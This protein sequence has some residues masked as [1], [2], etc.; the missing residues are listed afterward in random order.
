MDTKKF[1]PEVTTSGFIYLV[2]TVLILGHMSRFEW[3]T[4][5]GMLDRVKDLNAGLAAA[6]AGSIV[7]ASFVFGS[8]AGR[9]VGDVCEILGKLLRKHV[10]SPA[11]TEGDR[12][13]GLAMKK[14]PEILSEELQGRYVAKY[15]YRSLLF[16]VFW[17]QIGLAPWTL[18]SSDSRTMCASILI[19]VAIDCVLVAVFWSQ[20]RSYSS[21]LL[22]L[23]ESGIERVPRTRGRR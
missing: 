15:L 17:L 21:L 1:W 3:D 9:L 19:G 14:T 5:T 6:L 18:W 22:M 2:G 8:V 13:Y 7:A 20:R 16:A 10:K 23:S 4:L 12:I 11:V